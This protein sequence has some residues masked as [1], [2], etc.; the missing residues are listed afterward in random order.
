MDDARF[1][2]LVGRL[3]ASFLRSQLSSS[4]LCVLGIP[5]IS[6]M[7]VCPD[8]ICTIPTMWHDNNIMMSEVHIMENLLKC[9]S[10]IHLV[11]LAFELVE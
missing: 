9:E 2:V 8:A 6:V 1:V 3:K 5:I 10:Y 4:F 7:L 11:H